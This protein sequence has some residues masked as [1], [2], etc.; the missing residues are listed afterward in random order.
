MIRYALVNAQGLIIQIGAVPD[1]ECLA[2]QAEVTGLTAVPVDDDVAEDSHYWNGSAFEPFPQP[3]PGPW[4]EWNGQAWID[5]RTPAAHAAELAAARGSAS[6]SKLAFLMG[7]ME[8]G[9]LSP[10]EV[11]AAAR[12]EIPESFAGVVAA[13]S[14]MERDYASVYWAAARQID[15][16]HPLILMVAAGAGISES[17]LDALFGL[18]PIDF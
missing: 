5:P 12:G 16:T 10:P 2:L 15:R 14:P 17:T 7:C 6:L 4:A 11:I 3:R 18:S 9:L 13:L 8:Y 1:Q